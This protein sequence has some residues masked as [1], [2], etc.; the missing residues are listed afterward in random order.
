MC[1]LEGPPISVS[2]PPCLEQP[3]CPQSELQA[4][5]WASY[6]RDSKETL[7]CCKSQG[8]KDSHILD[9]RSP[10][11]LPQ[12]LQME[13]FLTCHGWSQDYP[14]ILPVEGNIWFPCRGRRSISL[15]I[16]T[17]PSAT[18]W[19]RRNFPISESWL[20]TRRAYGGSV[21]RAL[22]LKGKN[23]GTGVRQNLVPILSLPLQNCERNYALT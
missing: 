4:S 10:H 14:G 15:H 22:R 6:P 13:S 11:P 8:L 18:G 17:C 12:I 23:R 1:A 16:S 21:H 5:P 2:T 19:G 9:L 20:C 3:P 7:T